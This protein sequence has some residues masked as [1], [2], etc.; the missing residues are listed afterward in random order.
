MRCGG[1]EGA[2]PQRC[3]SSD[4]RQRR[5]RLQ[6]RS[7]LACVVHL[8]QLLLHLRRQTV[9][10]GVNIQRQLCARARGVPSTAPRPEHSVGGPNSNIALARTL[11]SRI[12]HG[13]FTGG[14]H[15]PR[16]HPRESFSRPAPRRQVH[17]PLCACRR[18]RLR[19]PPARPLCSLAQRRRPQQLPPALRRRPQQQELSAPPLQDC[20]LPQ[21][22]RSH[23][24]RRR[25]RPPPASWY[26]RRQR[27]GASPA[28]AGA[29]DSLAPSR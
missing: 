25:R 29:A 1:E 26:D 17:S 9:Q 2:P 20:P 13:R 24:R 11:C 6:M 27:S 7:H 5:L 12:I 28:P 23:P 18:P 21:R 10:G 3:S 4:A 8:L 16:A 14:T 22:R 15:A 19:P